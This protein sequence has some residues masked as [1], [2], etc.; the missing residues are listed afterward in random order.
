MRAFGPILEGLRGVC[1]CLE[2][3][4]FEGKPARLAGWN[5]TTAASA[6]IFAASQAEA[7]RNAGNR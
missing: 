7:K 1:E 3:F 4:A 5:V 2:R 6:A